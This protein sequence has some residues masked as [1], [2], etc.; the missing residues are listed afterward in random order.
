VGVVQTSADV[1]GVSVFAGVSIPAMFTIVDVDG[2]PSTPTFSLKLK[3]RPG[4]CI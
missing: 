4:V 3:I 2:R 1:A